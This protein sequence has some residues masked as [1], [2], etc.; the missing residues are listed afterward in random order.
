MIM[1]WRPIETAPK[2]GTRILVSFGSIGVHLVAWTQGSNTSWQSWCVDDRK[3][4]PYPLRGW[5]DGHSSAPTAWMPVP[6]PHQL[7]ETS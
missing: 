5:I 3:F 6:D 2:D 1:F 4:G 7:D